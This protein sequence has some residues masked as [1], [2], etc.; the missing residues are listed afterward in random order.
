LSEEK[1]FTLEELARYDGKKGNRAYI[2][3]QGKVYDV[4]DN[5]YWEDGDHMGAHF[6]GHDLTPEIADAPHGPENL[7]NAKLIG[8]LAP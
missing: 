8:V 5:A 4:T 7:E 3:F 6:A 1:R 2:A